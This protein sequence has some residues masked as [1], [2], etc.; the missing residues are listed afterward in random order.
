M[1]NCTDP[2]SSSFSQI[3]F[4]L[5]QSYITDNEGYF[6]IM[7]SLHMCR[8]FGL[9]NSGNTIGYNA[10]NDGGGGGGGDLQV[11]F[12]RQGNTAG[13]FVTVQSQFIFTLNMISLSV[14]TSLA[15]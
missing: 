6:D 3:T 7:I 2:V 8:P 11:P 14:K 1:K 15:E 13:Q 10:D 12:L 9:G 5:I 4:P